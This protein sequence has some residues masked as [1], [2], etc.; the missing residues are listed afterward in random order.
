VEVDGS[1]AEVQTSMELL[2]KP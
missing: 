2:K 1:R